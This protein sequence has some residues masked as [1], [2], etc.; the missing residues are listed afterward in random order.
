[1]LTPHSRALA[2]LDPTKEPPDGAFFHELSGRSYRVYRKGEQ[3]RHEEVLR[4]AEGKEIA[5]VDVPIRY[6][7]GSG[8]FCRSYLFEDD[9]FLHESPITWYAARHKWDMSPGYDFPQHWSFERPIRLGCAACHAGRVEPQPDAVGGL[10]FHEKA[11]GCENCHGPGSLH[12]ALQESG[13]HVLG[14]EDLTIV[15]PAKLSRPLQEAI[16]AACHLNGPASVYLRGRRE[17]DFRPGMPLTDYRTDYRFDTGNDQMTVVGH[18]EQLRQSV[19]YQKSKDLTCL[20]CHDPHLPEKPKE[21]A[22]AT[23]FYREKCLNCHGTQGCRLAEAERLKKDATDNCMACHMPRGDTEIPHIAF[24]HHRIGLHSG[25]P[26]AFPGRTPALA[27]TDDV[28]RLPALDRQRNLGLAFMQAADVS[29]YAAYADDFRQQARDLLEAVHQAGLRE[30]ETA[31]ALGVLSW[32]EN[33][34][35]ASAY[36]REALSAKD[37]SPYVRGLA[38]SLL[39]QCEMQER[40][41]ESAIPLLEELVRLRCRAEDWRLLGQCYR[42]LRQPQKALEALNHA[43]AIQ[44][45]SPAV[46]YE[47]EAAYRQTGELALANEHQEKAQ[48]LL[49]HHQE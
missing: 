32:Q 13:K 2:D 35:R 25:K 3:F 6:L 26:P 48:W 1:M 28:S 34:I 41:F 19:C 15:N 45:S 5:R 10:I 37:L 20:T 27:P 49:Q 31:L 9:G 33:P 47:L 4:T 23:A 12:L 24:T 29:F 22:G 14:T 36:A 16:C 11:I 40:D 38:L 46:H 42:L 39:A 8:N 44:P 30:S 43:L 17:I 18:M 21:G 7:I